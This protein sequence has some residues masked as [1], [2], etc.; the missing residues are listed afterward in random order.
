MLA[1]QGT[2]ALR[3]VTELFVGAAKQA[4][5]LVE[6][7]S[8]ELAGFVAEQKRGEWHGS[9]VLQWFDAS[10][11]PYRF[12]HSAGRSNPGAWSNP[13]ADDLASAARLELDPAARKAIWKQLHSLAHAE[14]PAA[15]IVH[16]M[17][18]VLLGKHLRDYVPG[19]YGLRPEWAWVPAASRRH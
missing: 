4:G 18:T 17:A 10:G 9:L 14:Q 3:R 12:L 2:E 11:D 6:V 5:V 7:H 19:A 15:L 1:L 13:K 16:P 8:R